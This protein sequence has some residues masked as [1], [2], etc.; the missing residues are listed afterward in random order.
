MTLPCMHCDG[1]RTVLNIHIKYNFLAWLDIEI[2]CTVIK[3]HLHLKTG[4]K[5]NL[6]QN[7]YNLTSCRRH[8]PFF[9]SIDL[10]FISFF[11]FG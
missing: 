9:F 2:G 6:C 7:F 11:D 5:K 4:I 1:Q 8:M 3:C 10:I